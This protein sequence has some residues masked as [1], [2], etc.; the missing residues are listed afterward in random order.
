MTFSKVPAIFFSHHSYTQMKH[1][2]FKEQGHSPL[3]EREE[4]AVW[5]CCSV[6]TV[7]VP[8]VAI[9][10]SVPLISLHPGFSH[11][12]KEPVVIRAIFQL[13]TISLLILVNEF[14][15]PFLYVPPAPV[16]LRPSLSQGSTLRKSLCR[17]F[18]W[19]PS[20]KR[21]PADSPHPATPASPPLTLSPPQRA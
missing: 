14:A 8:H 21:R 5:P 19:L 20:Y 13:F 7:S 18:F 15:Q 1:L 10:S 2:K 4:V 11:F 12:W 3:S 17:C 16:F 9:F 6:Q